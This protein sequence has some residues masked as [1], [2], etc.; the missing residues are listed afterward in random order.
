MSA[1]DTII[2]VT[3]K[4]LGLLVAVTMLVGALIGLGGWVYKRVAPKPPPNPVCAK[5]KKVILHGV[6]KEIID[7]FKDA[8]RRLEETEITL[9]G[10]KE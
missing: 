1:Y 10:G 2:I 5:P 8:N 4:T 7:A 6:S 9:K 3:I